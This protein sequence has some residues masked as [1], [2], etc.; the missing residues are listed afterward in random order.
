MLGTQDDGSGDYISCDVTAIFDGLEEPGKT[1]WQIDETR[2]LSGGAFTVVISDKTLG[3]TW[4][5][6]PAN[7]EGI[8]GIHRI[9]QPM[10]DASIGWGF[11][12]AVFE[13]NDSTFTIV[14][15]NGSKIKDRVDALSGNDYVLLWID[16]ECIAVNSA[17]LSGKVLT[18][19]VA[20]SNNARGLF[21]S[22]H[23]NHFTAQYGGHNPIVSDCPVSI[24]DKPCFVWA[25]GLDAEQ[26]CYQLLTN[27][28]GESV[29][30][31]SAVNSATLSSSS[32]SPY[33]QGGALRMFYNGVN[34][35][36]ARQA[37]LTAGTTYR[38]TGY[39]RGD[40][41]YTP[42]IHDHAGVTLWTGT[43]STSWQSIDVVFTAT[44]GS[45]LTFYSAASGSGWAE[46]D[47]LTLTE[48]ARP[49]FDGDP[50][51]PPRIIVQPQLPMWGKVSPSI[52]SQKGKT[53]IRCLG[54][55]SQLDDETRLPN[56]TGNLARYVFSRSTN[57][58]ADPATVK[59]TI[60][61]PHLVIH[62]W[63]TVGANWETACIWLC[64]QGTTIGFDTREDVLDALQ[65]ELNHVMHALNNQVSGPTG[66]EIQ[67]LYKYTIGNDGL[68]MMEEGPLSHTPIQ[69]GRESWI[70][71]P[72][73]ILFN[74]GLWAYTDDELMACYDACHWANNSVGDVHNSNVNYHPP[75]F[76]P[77]L[78]MK[79]PVY[80]DE[81]YQVGKHYTP[82]WHYST[83]YLYQWAWDETDFNQMWQNWEPE[84]KDRFP[85]PAAFLYIRKDQ[86][87][88]AV[89]AT[90]VITIGRHENTQG[91]ETRYGKITV[92][93]K[94]SSGGYNRIGATHI[95]AADGSSFEAGK[96]IFFVPAKEGLHPQG[97]GL[98]DIG[99]WQDVQWEETGNEYNPEDDPWRLSITVE[100]KADTPS[101]I[102]QSI[103]G[104]TGASYLAVPSTQT[105]S[106]V[107]GFW[108]DGDFN[109]CID[110]TDLDDKAA[111][112]FPGARW[113]LDINTEYNFKELLFDLIL[114][115]GLRPVW[116]WDDTTYQFKMRF[117][118]ITTTNKTTV[119]S[120]G[121]TLTEDMILY[122]A[123][124]KEVHNDTWLYNKASVKFNSF[125]GRYKSKINITYASANAQ[126]RNS[127]KEIKI[128]SDIVKIDGFK[129]MGEDEISKITRHFGNILR[130]TA[131][132][133]PVFE[134]TTTLASVVNHCPGC[135]I[136]ITDSAGF[137][138]YTHVRGLT[139]HPATVTKLGIDLNKKSC[140]VAARLSQ[141]Y[142]LG[143]A[144]VAFVDGGNSTK[145]GIV[146]AG[147]NYQVTCTT[148]LHTFSGSN[149]RTDASWFDCYNWNRSTNEYE[150]RSCSCSSYAV[151]A[152]R[153]DLNQITADTHYMSATVQ[154][155]TP[156]TGVVVLYMTSTP[157]TNWDTT[158]PYVIKFAA[159]DSCESCQQDN[160]IWYAD[161]TGYVG[162]ANVTGTRW[163]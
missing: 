23:Q 145:D 134:T 84:N 108:D 63:D 107:V 4:D 20:D 57:A 75:D 43:I 34:D 5:H 161:Q 130:V 49:T 156:A 22:P 114:F 105:L 86:D 153:T 46:F 106:H 91:Q 157:Y 162:T 10:N 66:S 8:E 37:V 123:T 59:D 138:P 44:G 102:F 142:T 60:A 27:G 54:S 29:T 65:E 77:G 127:S 58:S 15:Q 25:I 100:G 3:H 78:L 111:L 31:W 61:S 137:I 16:N 76:L 97:H 109:S 158:K 110:W 21:R 72:L 26:K 98:D 32:V 128:K 135:E 6:A 42:Y 14:E 18:L 87:F 94:S 12:D 112:S 104:R 133:N 79:V 73:A 124:H 7:F 116:E 39:G 33:E 80:G 118:P 47:A 24:I 71:G 154:S 45:N 70:G 40:A 69:N 120:E 64:D 131:V 51:Q 149:E 136:A 36:G 83:R 93:S 103:L 119:M 140:K 151:R 62:E 67:T 160:F 148:E 55:L 89:D 68:M 2:G 163:L 99:S 90:D 125:E 82:T 146:G 81:D 53:S 48:L 113:E 129:E 96:S 159:Y 41:A 9:A 92:S 121:R 101:V 52:T 1:T 139:S 155:V 13:R 150:A 143:W 17:S 144:P 126:S 11:L 28:D 85:V 30:G 88:D 122:G 117:V 50:L 19:T 38:L 132:P 74:L 152:I 95:D 35:P 141:N 147:P 56:W 115:C